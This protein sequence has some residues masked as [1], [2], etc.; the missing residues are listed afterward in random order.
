[1]ADTEPSTAEPETEEPT[2][3]VITEEPTTEEPTTEEPAAV[4]YYL[5]GYINGANYACEE[6]AAN[7]GEYK[8]ED[9]TLTT[10][11]EQDSYVA[12]KTTGNANWYMTKGWLGTEVTEA[13]LYN[14]STLGNDANKLFVPGGVEVKFTL[15][16]CDDDTLKLSYET[17]AVPTTEEPTTE[18][19]T[20]EEP[21]TEE[22]TTEEPTTE[23]PAAVDYYLFGYINGANY[24]CEEDAANM[25]EYKFVDGT[26]TAKFE[27][28]SYVAVKT[29][30]NA[31]WYMTDGW[32]GTDVTEATLYNTTILDNDANKLFVPGGRGVT[33]TL[34]VCEDDTLKLSYV[35]D[36][37]PSTAEPETEE[38][39]TEV[40]TEEPTT[41]EPTTE[42][43]AA[44]D[45]YLFGYING[46]NY[47]CEEDA[48]NMGEYK[49][50]DGTLTA[51]FEQDSYVAVKTTGNAKWYMTD[52]WL[53]TEVTEATLYN[54]TNLG[55]DA[56]KL[57][58]PGGVEVTFTLTA[59]NEKD[60]LVL[61]YSQN[62][63]GFPL[64]D[65]NE[66]GV[67]TIQDATL[68]QRYLAEFETLTP[69]QLKRAD[70]T[71]DGKVNIKD[72]TEIQRFAAEYIT[73]F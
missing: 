70:V 14:T 61:S 10:Q 60:T 54:T 49:F 22:P 19:P 46:A 48:A 30:G 26:L 64:G 73:S 34:T 11:F 6:D 58:V 15:T 20:T 18:E 17:A 13:T 45:Y 69:E 1:M 5:F 16:V 55:E 25:G 42:E 9:G 41:E 23:E 59:G 66:D 56:N 50:V 47:A 28:D 68:L 65:L 29:T 52:G 62:S 31:K 63:T 4:D 33:F 35:A 53:G 72:V 24:A 8:F 32:L 71:K 43:P 7:M 37:E 51:K 44:V 38:P 12:V 27:Q 21:T 3:E 67:V 39:T 2:T 40:I 36:T 57:F